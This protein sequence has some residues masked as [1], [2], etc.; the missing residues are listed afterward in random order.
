M[1][2][3]IYSAV[4]LDAA[5]YAKLRKWFEDETGLPAYSSPKNPHMT[6]AFRSTLEEVEALPLGRKV[7]LSVVAVAEDDDLQAVEVSGFPSKNPIPHITLGTTK[8]VDSVL[9]QNLL[10]GG[11]AKVRGP[12]LVGTVG[13]F[14][15][16][17]IR[18]DL[19]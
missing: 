15:G 6:I 19:D 8:R 12:R 9:S 16:S 1:K 17:G 4:F 10:N 5:N 2:T 13:Y 18:F 14:D 3:P 11:R 7:T